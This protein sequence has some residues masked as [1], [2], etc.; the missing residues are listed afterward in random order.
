MRLLI[1]LVAA[2]NTASFSL[3][4]AIRYWFVCPTCFQRRGGLYL[5]STK[6]DFMCRYCNNLTYRSQTR[7]PMTDYGH[8]SRQINKL[9]SEIKHWK[10]KGKPTR[11]VKKLHMLERKIHKLQKYVNNKLEKLHARGNFGV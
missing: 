11:K 9:R 5:T 7:D 6:Y 10:W 2:P 8:T 1:A 4:F 3:L